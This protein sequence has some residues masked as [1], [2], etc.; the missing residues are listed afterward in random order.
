MISRDSYYGAKRM[1]TD[2]ESEDFINK[3]K[4]ELKDE[5]EKIMIVKNLYTARLEEKN[6]MEKL[7]RDCIGDYKD[8]LWEIKTKLKNVEPKDASALDDEIKNQ[9]KNI[10][11]AEKKLTLIYDNVFH[12]KPLLRESDTI[13]ERIAP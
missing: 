3:I 9:I 11:E 2:K 6:E 13:Q 12:L 4:K 8:Q 1:P 5:K 7:L 10:L